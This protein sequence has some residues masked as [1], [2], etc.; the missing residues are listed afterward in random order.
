[1]VT[2][3]TV[4]GSTVSLVSL[5]STPGFRSVE[6]TMVDAVAIV[7]SPFTG[8]TQAQQWPGADSW[9]GTVTLPPMNQTSTD[10]WTTFLM[11]MRGMANS[12]QIG[13]PM[14]PGPVGQ[15]YGTPLAASGNI[16]A[17]QQLLTTGWVANGF[18]LLLPG[19]YIQLGYRLHRN[20]DPVSSDANGNATLN[21]WPSLREVPTV[22]EPLVFNNPQGLWR[23]AQNK[24]TWSSDYT[25]LS[26]ISFQ[27][28]E[29]R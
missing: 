19:D 24:R 10:D 22:G 4:G 29:Y 1:M 13:D 23:L 6:F 27:I 7:Q 11:Q 26:R 25:R 15:I 21:I 17:S 14:K 28:M 3:I 2:T 18:R 9:L 5:P 20:L 8:Q 16:A 12:V